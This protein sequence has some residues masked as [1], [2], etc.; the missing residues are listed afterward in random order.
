MLSKLTTENIT[1]FK[2]VT[3]VLCVLLQP[4]CKCGLEVR[5]TSEAMVIARKKINKSS[6]SITRATWIESEFV[7]VLSIFL[8]VKAHLLPFQLCLCLFLTSQASLLI[9]GK[10][11]DNSQESKTF[12][13]CDK[14]KCV[15]S[16]AVK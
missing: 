14:K 1:S 9:S 3:L 2:T 8:R 6:R 10:R 13:T 16:E 12:V 7:F 15:K 5:M 11:W 4:T